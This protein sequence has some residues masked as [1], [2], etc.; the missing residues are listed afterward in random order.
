VNFFADTLLQIVVVEFVGR[1]FVEDPAEAVEACKICIGRPMSVEN[2][3]GEGK[4]EPDDEQSPDHEAQ[5]SQLRG[6]I[7]VVRCGR[8]GVQGSCVVGIEAR[9]A[10]MCDVS[11]RI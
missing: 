5:I 7:G 8:Q 1:V 4:D 2:D 9:D 6:R 11:R 10:S 3:D